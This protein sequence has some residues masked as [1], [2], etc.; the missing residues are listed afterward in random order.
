MELLIRK[1]SAYV[2]DLMITFGLVSIFSFSYQVFM[3]EKNYSK[4][5]FMLICAFICI[6]ILLIYIPTST[7]GQT[8]GQKTM[9][10]RVVN[11]NKT[12]RTYFQSFIRECVIKFAF[13]SISLPIII[14][15]EI[16]YYIK[17]RDFKGIH[18]ILLKT[19]IIKETH[20]GII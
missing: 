11:D 13:I 1:I 7:N 18:D 6:C 20:H 19:T 2:L 3:F 9:K 15:S 8:I 17:H 12:N 5:N 4:A 14:I 16:I 10:I